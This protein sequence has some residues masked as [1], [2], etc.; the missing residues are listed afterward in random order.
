MR[1]DKIDWLKHIFFKAIFLI[2]FF[3]LALWAFEP[4]IVTPYPVVG[5]KEILFY[6]EF[7]KMQRQILVW[8]PVD[9]LTEGVPSTN[10]WDVFNV[11][12]NAPV[13]RLQLKTPLIV[14]S[15]GYMGN[16][17]Q[18]S[19]LIR[20]CVHHGFTVISIQH[21]DLINGHIHANH[22]QRAR[23]IKVILDQ[24]LSN[25][26]ADFV[27]ANQI[28]VTGYSLGGTT[29]IWVA[30]GRT[31][32]LDNMIPSSEFASIADFVRL[33]EVLPTLN[34]EMLSKDWR[35]PR[36]RAAFI[37]A[38]AWSWIFDEQSLSQISIPT[39]LIASED[40]K[41]VV[42]KSN[43][44]FFARHIPHAIY[45]SIL[46]KASHFIFISAL[47]D[48]QRKMLTS[49]PQVDFLLMDDSS[50]DR[51]WIQLQ[52]SEEATRFFNSVFKG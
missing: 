13:A 5:F 46:G 21:N 52:I 33:E 10:P 3:P 1:K 44:G 25:S 27:N 37:M 45:Q 19:W 2:F 7:Q 31:T 23:D 30:G 12:V 17:H 8:Y 41:V 47:N 38:P 4:L 34:K 6:D 11:A 9:A 39:Y 18:L 42:A 36:I 29:A 35:E 48:R 40:D 28:A 32:K 16:P 49:N 26:F 20:S 15:H 14:F 50:I 51:S 22:W 43:A 24:F